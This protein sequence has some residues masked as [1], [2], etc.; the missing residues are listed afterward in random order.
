VAARSADGPA[1][2]DGF[3]AGD[4]I[5][6]LNREPIATVAALRQIL[7][8]LKPGDAVAVQIERQGRLRFLAFQ[9][10]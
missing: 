1:L 2:E 4:V 6:A 9:L 10:P 8:K 5:F 3:R 7:R